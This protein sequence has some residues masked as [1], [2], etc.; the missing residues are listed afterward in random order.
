MF[1]LPSP[2]SMLYDKEMQEEEEMKSLK[3]DM[4][5]GEYFIDMW[6]EGDY[7]YVKSNLDR[8]W[9]SINV[10][11]ENIDFIEITDECK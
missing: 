3:F 10:P 1:Q 8:V 6:V 9:K 4:L 2:S 7:L 5:E 11:M